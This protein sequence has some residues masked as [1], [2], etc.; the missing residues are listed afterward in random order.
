MGK[1]KGNGNGKK[2]QTALVTGASGGIG[3]EL[4]RSLA[5]QG[6]DLVLVARR[7]DELDKLAKELAADHGVDTTVIATDLGTLDAPEKLFAS[8]KGT[9]IDVLVNN[10]GFGTYGKFWE[11]ENTRDLQQIQLNVAALVNLTKLFVK[12]MVERKRGRI[13]NVAS[14]A[15]FQPGPLMAVYYATKAFVLSF[16]EAIATEL[17]GTGVTVTALCPGP[18]ESGFQAS[19]KMQESGLFKSLPVADSKSVA[20]AGIAGLLKGKV[21]VVPGLVNKIGIQ[22]NRLTPRAVVRRL[23]KRMQSRRGN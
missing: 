13:L 23:V 7:K 4:A 9:P 10:A 15:A 21:I 2:R 22:A 11:I 5:R 8:L 14:T 20:E 12:P 17:A 6:F 18:T 19:A 3:L 16:S 1:A